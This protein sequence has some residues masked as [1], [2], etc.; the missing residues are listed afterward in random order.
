MAGGF[1][2]YAA[3][4]KMQ[5]RRTVVGQDNVSK[6]FTIPAR[7]DDLMSGNAAIKDFVLK[8]GDLVVVPTRAW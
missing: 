6:D 8:T 5:V 3:K 2:L 4:N 1:T 7:Y